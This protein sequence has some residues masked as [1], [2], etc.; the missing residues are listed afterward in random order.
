MILI[1]LAKKGGHAWDP[2]SVPTSVKGSSNCP[3]SGAPI[4]FG[5]N[6]AI[7]GRG[8]PSTSLVIQVGPVMRERDRDKT[9]AV[10]SN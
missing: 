5:P 7:L 1:I 8:P 2:P 10:F 9:L 6:V 4:S 3:S